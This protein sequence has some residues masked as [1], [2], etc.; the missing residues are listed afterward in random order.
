M[1]CISLLTLLNTTA[2]LLFTSSR[3]TS[4]SETCIIS[5]PLECFAPPPRAF[6]QDFSFSVSVFASLVCTQPW[7]LM[8]FPV[9]GVSFMLIRINCHALSIC[10]DNGIHHQNAV[11]DYSVFMNLTQ[12]FLRTFFKFY[13]RKTPKRGSY[14][15]IIG[16]GFVCF[17][18]MISQEWHLKFSSHEMFLHFVVVG[19]KMVMRPWDTLQD[20]L[21]HG[22]ELCMNP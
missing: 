21:L 12:T 7:S 6:V 17:L 16:C 15:T 11:E 5:S 20:S 1:D 22:V 10:E 13:R 8:P 14:L 19:G 3:S 18:F 4:T 9:I 2:C